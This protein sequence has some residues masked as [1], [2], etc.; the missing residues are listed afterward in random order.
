MNIRLKGKLLGLAAIA[1]IGMGA[2]TAQSKDVAIS[3]TT[4][5]KGVAPYV[6]D[7]RNV[8]ATSGSGLCWRT[9]FWSPAAVQTAY[10]GSYPAGCVCDKDLVPADM[11]KAP[12]WSK[13]K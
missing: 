1:A 13:S 3:F 12:D 2:A 7:S 8:I 11:C 9:G 5:D 4:D 10:S 6:L